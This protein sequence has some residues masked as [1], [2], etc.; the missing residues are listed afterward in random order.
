MNLTV[1]TISAL[2]HHLTTG[3]RNFIVEKKNRSK[4]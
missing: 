1:K 3:G 2:V 4:L